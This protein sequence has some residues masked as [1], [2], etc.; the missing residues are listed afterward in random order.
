[1]SAM[2]AIILATS[3]S[4]ISS[5]LSLFCARKCLKA[6]QRAEEYKNAASRAALAA[7]QHSKIASS[8][9]NQKTSNEP[10]VVNCGDFNS[11]ATAPKTEAPAETKQTRRE[12]VREQA[13]SPEAQ[14]R[15]AEIR[16]RRERTSPLI[17]PSSESQGINHA[18]WR[19]RV[20]KGPQ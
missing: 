16:Q 10:V 18:V 3:V 6:Q 20:Q 13:N 2:I 15:V 11:P 19:A 1:M 8:K 4:I 17:P 9:T 7:L 14:A 5:T 12:M